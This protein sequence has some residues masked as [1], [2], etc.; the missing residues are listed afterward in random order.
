MAFSTVEEI[1]EDFRH[2]RMVLIMDDEDRENEG[3]LII[4]ADVVTAEHITFFAR[5]ACGL[6]CLTLTEE[7]AAQLQLPLMVDNNNSLHETNFTVSIESA[8][9][10]T[11]GISAADRAKTVRTAVAR[12]AKPTDVVM[13]GHIFPLIAKRGGVLTRAG[14]T[15]AGCDLARLAGFEPASV[16]VEV[17]NEDGTMARGDDLARFAE[18]HNIKLGTIADLIQYRAIYDTTIELVSDKPISTRHGDFQLRTYTDRVS[19]A[20]HHALIK[21]EITEEDPC[22]VRVQVMNTLRDLLLTERPGFKLSWS[23]SDSLERIDQEGKGALVLVGQEHSHA[24]ELAQAIAFP[25]VPPIQRAN[26]EIG[27]YRLVGTGSQILR[28]IGVGKMRLLSSPIRFNA[29]SG[30]QLEV[31]EYVENDRG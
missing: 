9:G 6:I 26:D 8:E 14:H 18:T 29:I 23:L 13:P 20:V 30:F 24:D 22:L 17:M 2:G 19:D 5:Y 27:V 1:L 12:N 15:E 31:V 11:T 16:I 28:D 7:R 4:A 10:I 21:G 3:D 25:D